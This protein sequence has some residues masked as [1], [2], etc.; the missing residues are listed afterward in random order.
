MEISIVQVAPEQRKAKPV[1]ESKLG[2]GRVF[3]DHMFTMSYKSGQGWY[4]PAVR[5]YEDLRLDPAAMCLHY[6]QL[7]F[8]GMKAY[9]GKN[10]EIYLFRPLE[11]IKRMNESA[12]RLCMP[13]L[14]PEVFMEGLKKLVILEKD[15]IPKSSGASLYIRPTMIATE[16]ALGVHPAD[17]YLF[18]I[19]VGP[20]GAYYPEGFS[21]T[22]IYVVEE[23]VRS[24]PGG[25]GY[26]KAAGNY[27]ASLMASAMAIEKGYTQVLWLD[28]VDRKYVEEVGTSN[29]FFVIGEELITPPLA[30]TILP[31]VTRDSVLQI[32]RAWGLK[33]A[34]RRL[35]MD[36]ILAACG[37]GSLREAF[38][39]GTAAIVSPIGQICYRDREYPIN[40]GRIGALT[41]KLYEEIL[42]IQYGEKEDPFGWRLRIA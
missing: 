24:A 2:F 30:G 27:A 3:T 18:Y 34:E 26:C 29:I 31:G 11:N 19:I 39:S 33:V 10:G 12:R 9:R 6:G 20:V 4:D 22:K 7:I 32:A 41:E 8:E 35:A 17:A 1:D 36:E 38:A 23:Y 5:P 15:W 28:A 42:K 21:P 13:T 37:D 16:A 40:D 14:D 25:I